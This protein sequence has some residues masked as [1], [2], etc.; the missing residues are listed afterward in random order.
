M[1][2]LSLVDGTRCRAEIS[3]CQYNQPLTLDCI[4]ILCFPPGIQRR[5]IL[6]SSEAILIEHCCGPI[7]QCGT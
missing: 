5:K 2:I 4:H 6:K 7:S 1:G 3:P